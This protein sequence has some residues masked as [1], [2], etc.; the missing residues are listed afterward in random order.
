MSI[1]TKK[2]SYDQAIQYLRNGYCDS[3]K[4]GNSNKT[5]AFITRDNDGLVNIGYF[6][7]ND[8]RSN[9]WFLIQKYNLRKEKANV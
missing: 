5:Y 1:Q 6:N 8:Y 4:C 3:I 7:E 9:E 2:L